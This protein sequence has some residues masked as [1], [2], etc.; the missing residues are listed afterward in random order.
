MNDG[1]SNNLQL[2]QSSPNSKTSILEKECENDFVISGDSGKD[3][4]PFDDFFL[5]LALVDAL[6]DERAFAF[7]AELVFCGVS[8]E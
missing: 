5:L 3:G 6:L 1:T 8:S 2:Y 7:V 4:R